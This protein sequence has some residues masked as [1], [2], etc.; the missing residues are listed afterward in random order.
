[1]NVCPIYE[2]SLSHHTLYMGNLFIAYTCITYFPVSIK[3]NYT[4]PPPKKKRITA[5]I[6]KPTDDHKP[7]TFFG[8]MA[9]S[10]ET[11]LQERS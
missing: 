4:P 3:T 2:A 9:L 11:E 7:D 8:L 10:Q 1:M 6:L 5:P